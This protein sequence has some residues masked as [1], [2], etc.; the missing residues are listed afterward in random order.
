MFA[1]CPAS[2]NCV[3][4]DAVDRRHA[5]APFVPKSSRNDIWPQIRAAVV[6]VPRTKL[7]VDEKHYLRAECRS[8]VLGFTDDLE[9]QLRPKEGIL[10]VRSASR[11][12]YYDFGANR[13]RIEALRAILQKCGLVK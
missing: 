13:R 8:A 10:A 12:G 1:P 5:I 4:S 11:S 2:P 3:S 9:I 6:N 7:V